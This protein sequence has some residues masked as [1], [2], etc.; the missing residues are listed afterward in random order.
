MTDQRRRP[1]ETYES[2]AERRIRAAQSAGEFDH[3]PGFG[4]PIADIDEPLDENW[5]LRRKL[6]NENLQA[7]PP[8]LEARLEIERTL[9][10]L[11]NAVSESDVRH[12]LSA[13]N[14]SI[15]RAHFSPVAG[16]ADGVLPVDVE[17]VVADWKQ[18]R[19]HARPTT[20]NQ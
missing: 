17:R 8:V 13:L 7:L 2:F 18:R 15:R 3:L 9:Q 19:R 6:R 4:R 12:R 10:S 20:I 14:S 1:G 16:P 11:D 5:W